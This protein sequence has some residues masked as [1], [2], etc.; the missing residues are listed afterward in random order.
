VTGRRRATRV[1]VVDDEPAITDFI[2]LGLSREGFEVET[3]SDGRAA[4]TVVDRFAPTSSCW[5]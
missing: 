2:R 4:L 1:L 5:T 3:A